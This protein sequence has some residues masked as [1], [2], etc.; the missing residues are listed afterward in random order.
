MIAMSP[1]SPSAKDR[2]ARRRVSRRWLLSFAGLVLLPKCGLCVLAWF[3]LGT[4]FAGSAVEL[5]GANGSPFNVWALGVVV[6]LA[7]SG[8]VFWRRKRGRLKC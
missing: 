1:S 5:C 8:L 7:V 3:G 6:L 2:P 4:A